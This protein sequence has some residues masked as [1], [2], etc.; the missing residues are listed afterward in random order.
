MV[1]SRSRHSSDPVVELAWRA[2][3]T[4]VT[5]GA[6]IPA[7]E[8]SGNPKRAAC[9][10]SIHREPSDE[11]RGCIGTIA[12]T[13]ACLSEEVISNAITAATRDPR[14]PAIDQHELAD[15][16]VSVDVLMPPVRSE[17]TALD[18]SRYGVIVEQGTRRGV[19]L[20]ALEG[21]NSV[22]EQLMIACQK[23]GIDP[24]SIYKIERFEVVRHT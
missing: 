14:F 19:L 7:I 24:V 10:V 12:P 3:E 18:P 13:K 22:E 16:S 15:L 1:I 5:T 21:I 20:P 17:V 6:V 11:L 4:Y 8:L 2:I 9:F 23:A